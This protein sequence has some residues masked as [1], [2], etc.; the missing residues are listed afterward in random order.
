M[1]NRLANSLAMTAV[2]GASAKP[3]KISTIKMILL[4]NDLQKTTDTFSWNCFQVFFVSNLVS[5]LTGLD[6]PEKE[7]V[8]LLVHM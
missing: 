2:I 4:V 7:D 5:S 1:T 6:S 8:L 3:P